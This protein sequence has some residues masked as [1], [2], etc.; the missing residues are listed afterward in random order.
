MG[1][2]VADLLVGAWCVWCAAAFV[3]S[4]SPCRRR[5]VSCLARYV[6]GYMYTLFLEKLL[7]LKVDFEYIAYSQS[8]LIQQEQ[9]VDLL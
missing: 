5:V 7:D 3:G 2:M 1:G 4:P 8:L 6:Y 9:D